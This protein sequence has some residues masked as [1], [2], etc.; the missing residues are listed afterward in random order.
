[1]DANTVSD[2]F[3]A[4]KKL[5]ERV[6]T[7]GYVAITIGSL[8]DACQST[9]VRGARGT[10][11]PSRIRAWLAGTKIAL[12]NDVRGD[13]RRDRW[14]LLYDARKESNV[15]KL[16]QAVDAVQRKRVPCSRVQEY[17]QKL[18]E[19]AKAVSDMQR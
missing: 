18:R 12:G 15:A 17:A 7:E 10:F 8:K 14:V 13:A 16:F 19:A 2:R 1:M 9:H 11:P 3:L 5:V 6:Q 4:W